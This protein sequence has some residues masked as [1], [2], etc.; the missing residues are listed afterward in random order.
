M[1]LPLF[2]PLEYICAIAGPEKTK[3]QRKNSP[4][5]SNPIIGADFEKTLINLSSR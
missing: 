5:D 4:P 2:S 1:I 3:N